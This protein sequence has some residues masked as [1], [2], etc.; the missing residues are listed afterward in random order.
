[1][2]SRDC[3]LQA[4]KHVSN[5]SICA[6]G[7]NPPQDIALLPPG[8]IDV[9]LQECLTRS[10]KAEMTALGTLW[11]GCSI[12]SRLSS[13]AGERASCLGDREV[14]VRDANSRRGFIGG[15]SVER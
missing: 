5:C 2:N 9:V 13:G 1:M 14:G 7:A 6:L 4:L 15:S 8:W 12:A 10:R 3:L 11:L